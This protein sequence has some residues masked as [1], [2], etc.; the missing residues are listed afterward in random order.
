MRLGIAKQITVK[1]VAPL[2]LQDGFNLYTCEKI[3]LPV[4]ENCRES[5]FRKISSEAV[6]GVSIYSSQAKLSIDSNFKD[7]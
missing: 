2:F 3:N 7:G 5:P 6:I 1:G 4:L